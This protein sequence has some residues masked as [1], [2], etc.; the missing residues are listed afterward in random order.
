MLRKDFRQV[1]YAKTLKHVTEEFLPFRVNGKQN[2]CLSEIV[3]ARGAATQ[4]FLSWKF[5]FCTINKRKIQSEILRKA[6]VVVCL[7]VVV[8]LALNGDC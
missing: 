6:Q 1:V 5:H 8:T 2:E 3:I 4:N 7:R